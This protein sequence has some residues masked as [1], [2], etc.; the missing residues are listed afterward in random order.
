MK[1]KHIGMAHVKATRLLELER[2]SVT[3]RGIAGD[4]QFV[5]LDESGSPLPPGHHRHYLPLKFDFDEEKNALMLTYPDGSWVAE[6]CLLSEE[7]FDLDFL[8]MRN[9]AVRKVEG[10]WN[11]RLGKFSGKAVTIVRVVRDGDGIDVLPITLVTTGSLDDLSKR[12]GSLVD[13]RRFRANLVIEHEEPFA[14]DGWDGKTMRIGSA[15]LRIRSSV[16]RCVVTQLDP[17]TG[18][19]NARTI[20]ALMGFRQSVNLPDGLMVDYATP[21]FASYAEVRC[22]GEVA[23]GDAVS[24][25]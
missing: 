1:V 2:A 6:D 20:P 17:D 15:V 12:M 22:S 16:P 25:V 11:N 19:N 3:A 10:E 13:Y 14:E 8:G 18:V 24:F 5:L 4:R 7:T 23:V 9:I 21:G